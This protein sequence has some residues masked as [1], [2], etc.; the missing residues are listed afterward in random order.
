MYS[1]QLIAQILSGMKERVLSCESWEYLLTSN[2]PGYSS[3]LYY[4]IDLSVI[5]ISYVALLLVAVQ[6]VSSRKVLQRLQLPISARLSIW[7]LIQI[8]LVSIIVRIIIQM[9]AYK[10]LL[11]ILSQCAASLG[12]FQQ[13]PQMCERLVLQTT[14]VIPNWR[15]FF[16]DLMSALLPES[17]LL[18]VAITL[19]HSFTSGIP[20]ATIVERSMRPQYASEQ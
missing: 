5:L 6:Q 2:I 4:V 18:F 20:R 14:H 9:L 15:V 1:S 10:R 8:G 3:R 13:C 12:P 7:L 16:M 11:S 19:A 17:I